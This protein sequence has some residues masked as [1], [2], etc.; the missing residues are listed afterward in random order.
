MGSFTALDECCMQMVELCLVMLYMKV[1][2][3]GHRK[4]TKF[5]RADG[6]PT[7]DCLDTFMADNLM[8]GAVIRPRKYDEVQTVSNSFVHGSCLHF[9]QSL[10]CDWMLTLTVFSFDSLI[11]IISLCKSM[12]LKFSRFDISYT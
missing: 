2:K 5:S 6:R 1:K 11:I 10:T 12:N 8:N 7:V 3:R 4:P 9:F